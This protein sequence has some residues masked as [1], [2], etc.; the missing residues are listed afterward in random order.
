[1]ADVATT[2]LHNIGN[3]LNSVNVSTNVLAELL[4]GS[5]RGGL[6]KCLGLLLAQPEPGRFLD[7]DPKGKK[8]LPYLSAVDAALAV[9]REK[10][11]AELVSLS[12]HVEHIKSIVSQQLLSARGDAKG[13]RI[14]ERVSL[15]EVVSDAILVLTSS[16]DD[17]DVIRFVREGESMTVE[18]DRHKLFQVL[19]NLLVNA[20]DAVLAQKGGGTVA[21]RS[22]RGEG[23][24]IELE[25]SDDGVGMDEATKQRMFNHGFTTKAHGH[26]FGLHSSACAAI[27]LGGTLKAHSDGKGLGATFV[28]TVRSERQNSRA[29]MPRVTT[30]PAAERTL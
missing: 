25:V 28:L 19:L 20:K 16:L 12:K 14:T 15:D 18:T 24:H 10:M 26:G 3:V 7:V 27:E 22:R 30:P 17:P 1:M 13:I 2:V 8:V 11:S 9:E 4:K 6:G 23:G 21:V 5:S 29:A